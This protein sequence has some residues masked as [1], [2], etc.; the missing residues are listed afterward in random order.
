MWRLLEM[1]KKQSLIMESLTIIQNVESIKKDSTILPSLKKVALR[2]YAKRLYEI[3]KAMEDL[4][5][6]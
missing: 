3:K 4:Q 5:D 6:E 1:N 2:M